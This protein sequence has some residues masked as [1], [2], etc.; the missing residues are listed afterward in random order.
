MTPPRVEINLYDRTAL[1]CIFG[2]S[3]N[4]QSFLFF[5]LSLY[6]KEGEKKGRELNISGEIIISF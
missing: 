2:Q 4:L 6:R 3:E 5:S 1:Y